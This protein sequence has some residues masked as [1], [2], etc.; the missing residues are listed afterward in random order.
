MTKITQIAPIYRENLSI[1]EICTN[2]FISQPRSLSLNVEAIDFL[3]DLSTQLFTHPRI[4]EYAEL[5]ALAFWMRKSNISQI[6][7]EF[8]ARIQLNE[9][10]V[11]RGIT[12][13]VAPSNVDSIFL[14]SWALSMIVGNINLVRVSSQQTE[15]MHLLFECIREQLQTGKFEKIAKRN[16]VITYPHDGGISAFISQQADVRCLWG[17]DNTINYFKTL[18]TKPT[19]KDI[20]FADKY[21]Y[22]IINAESY[23]QI[24]TPQ[25]KNVAHQFY[26][27]SYWFDQLACSSPRIVYFVGGKEAC[28]NASQ[29]FWEALREELT[30]HQY[31]DDISTAMDKHVFLYQSMMK[32]L[33]ILTAPNLNYNVPTV[34]RVEPSANRGGENHCGRGFFLECF[35]E[36]LGKL[37]PLVEAKDQT[38]S[39]WGFE[40][41]VIQELIVS[42][43]GKG[44]DRAVPIGQAL[45]FSSIWDGYI[46][47]TELTKCISV[48]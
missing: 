27:D 4:K 3:N 36:D 43:N 38:L 45:N 2:E 32:G 33:P 29:R 20:V 6:I 39:Y 48:L 21:S 11:P 22:S 13:H 10:L 26:N 31:V 18:A 15:Q 17:G 47:L 35:L 44:I 9:V 40:K 41:N 7:N 30:K 28:E 24:E 5:F 12:F 14:Y 16:V 25:L 1:S 37:V 42:I 34:I 8:R 46:L 19:T 23:N